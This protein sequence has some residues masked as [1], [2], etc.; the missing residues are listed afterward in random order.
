M[1]N[2]WACLSVFLV[3]GMAGRAFADEPGSQ[4][5]LASVDSLSDADLGRPF[6]AAFDPITGHEGQTMFP[7]ARAPRKTTV[8]EWRSDFVTVDNSQTLR[9]NAKAWGIGDVSVGVTSDRR[10]LVFRV[11]SVEYAE[12]VDDATDPRDVSPAIGAA[13]YLRKVYYGRMYEI[14]IAGSRD[15]FDAR[16]ASRLPVL[17]NTSVSASTVM[18]KYQLSVS[19]K[20]K[21]FEPKGEAV[22]ARNIDEIKAAYKTV[23]GMGKAVPILAEYRR[24]RGT[25]NPVETAID[26]APPQATGAAKLHL[27]KFHLAANRGD[28]TSIDVSVGE[29]DL[30]VGDASGNVKYSKWQDSVD[31]NAK[32]NG[33]LDVIVGNK[34]I[35]LT[36]Q[37]SF[38]GSAGSLR[39]RVRDDDWADNS[40]GYD[41]SLIVIPEESLRNSDCTKQQ[42]DGTFIDCH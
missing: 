36:K 37:F 1:G 3:A 26:F 4:T 8:N 17:L 11:R 39:F 9:A 5:V 13:Y 6:S 40:G 34:Q 38:G 32:G 20:A 7:K 23:D 19:Q 35:A 18:S 30:V 15:V 22:F 10:Y 41:I 14:V 12:E 24:I 2:S 42:A 27:R 33:G 21:G 29:H 31:A 25:P 16:L 28:W